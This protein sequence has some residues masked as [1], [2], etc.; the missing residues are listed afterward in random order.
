[1]GLFDALKNLGSAVVD[2][3][4]LPVDAAVDGLTGFEDEKTLRRLRKLK[5]ELEEAHEESLDD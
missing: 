4:L 3:A 2:T 5:R 1:M